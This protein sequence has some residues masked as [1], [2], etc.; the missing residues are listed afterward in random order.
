[1][2]NSNRLAGILL[3]LFVLVVIGCA[4]LYLSIGPNLTSFFSNKTSTKLS[5]S[6]YLVNDSLV[7]SSNYGS[8]YT[9][10]SYSNRARVACYTDLDC[11]D[12][13]YFTRD[14]CE[15]PGTAGSHCAYASNGPS[16]H[17]NVICNNNNDCNDNNSSTTDICLNPGTTNSSC[18]HNPNSV[19]GNGI[20]EGNE[21][22]DDGNTNN[23]D[24]CSNLCLIQN[25]T[26]S[27]DSQCDDDNTNTEDI[28]LNP[29]TVNSMCKHNPI[30]CN[31]DGQ[32]NDG[33]SSTLDKCNNPGTTG[34][35]CTNTPFN[36]GSNAQCGTT[37]FIGGEF[38]SDNGVMKNFQTSTCNNP[39]TSNSFCTVDVAPEQVSQCSFACFNGGTCIRCNENS[40]CNDN[41]SSTTDM[42]NNSNTLNSFCTN[43][44]NAVCGN[45]IKEGNEQCDDGNTNNNDACSNSCKTQTIT[46]TTD[47]QCND[48]N[49]LTLDKCLNPGTNTSS[50]SHIPIDCSNN[51][52]CDD[53][54]SST[55]D[56]CTNPGTVNSICEYTTVACMTNTDCGTDGFV[57]SNFCSGNNVSGNFKKF[58]CSNP[59]TASSSCSST[60]ENKTV[61]ACSDSCSNGMCTVNQ[62]PSNSVKVLNANTLLLNPNSGVL[63]TQLVTPGQTLKVTGLNG[64]FT[65]WK[66]GPL[67]NCD[68]VYTNSN[69]PP[70]NLGSVMESPA[71]GNFLGTFKNSVGI[72]IA[73]Y[74]LPSFKNGIV[75]PNGASKLE[76]TFPDNI[77]GDNSG[78]CP[79][80]IY[81]IKTSQCPARTC[82]SLTDVTLTFTDA[83]LI[84]HFV[85]SFPNLSPYNHKGIGPVDNT[86][87][88]ADAVCRLAGFNKGSI[89]ALDDFYSCGDNGIIR[90]NTTKNDFEGFPSC[91]HN[92]FIYKLVC[93]NP[94][95]MCLA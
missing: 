12:F 84:Q 6:L 86:Q 85:E 18:Q 65:Y 67:L 13:D 49:G 3:V 47:N 83:W 52:D 23:N 30:V 4:L 53:N 35:F 64:T 19:C 33:N 20:K 39:N 74:P 40:D 10:L 31:N 44:P 42:C 17:G 87:I 7:N 15:N 75:V 55:I 61:T 27:N 14:S 43:N 79:G 71:A 89:T 56:V 8:G 24:S 62:C 11:D 70:N 51:N 88:S 28:C 69:L 48:S 93:S 63:N 37:G 22:C 45:G 34:S 29:G 25:I 50:C 26:C 59:G 54:N 91:Q 94:T 58:T 16:G 5:N 46:C 90:W 36:C 73:S 80:V 82:N 66:S 81:N 1:M 2:N 78:P 68:T 60:T 72:V 41:N 38:C 21:Q 95:N 92:T 57:G 32:C 77:Y 76:F 9:D